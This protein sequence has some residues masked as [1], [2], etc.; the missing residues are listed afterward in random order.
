MPYV[1][2]SECDP[3][4]FTIVG[5]YIPPSECDPIEF[6]IGGEA[7]F[8]LTFNG[9]FSWTGSQVIINGGQE[10]N[11][12]SKIKLPDKQFKW[13][14]T[15]SKVEVHNRGDWGDA[16]V[17]DIEESIVWGNKEYADLLI[18]MPLGNFNL[19][20]ILVRCLWKQAEFLSDMDTAFPAAN[21]L[22]WYDLISRI[23][24][25]SF[26]FYDTSKSFKY[27]YPFWVDKFYRQKYSGLVDANHIMDML[28]GVADPVDHEYDFYWGPY[29]YSLW[30]QKQYYPPI[31]N[32]INF[33]INEP[34][35]T[36]VCS[37]ID[38]YIG[39]EESPRCPFKHKHSGIRD[40]YI[41]VPTPTDH[42][43]YM[44]AYEVYHMLN[45]IL[46]KRLP[47][48]EPLDCFSVDIQTDLD[49]WCWDFSITLPQSSFLDLVKPSVV[50]E[51]LVLID[52]EISINGWKW[53]CRVESWSESFSFGQRAWTIHGRSPSIELSEPYC[54]PG[55]YTNTSV[56]NG[57]QIL[58]EVLFGTGWSIQWG[59]D[60]LPGNYSD[61][62]N[63]T[64]TW[65]IPA[66]ACSVSEKTKLQTIQ[67]ILE[68]IDARIITEPNCATNK[69]LII[70]PRY[71]FTP[72]QWS[73]KTAD[74]AVNI[75]SCWETGGG[76]RTLPKINAVVVSGESQGVIVNAT[77]DGTAGNKIAP[78]FTHPLITTV[79]AGSERA[80]SIL[81]EEGTWNDHTFKLFSLDNY[82]SP[83]GNIPGLLLPGKLLSVI[84]D[85][86][87]WKG[88]VTS[89]SIHGE[90]V[91]ENK[92]CEVTQTIEVEEYYG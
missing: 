35:E 80:K 33:H 65:N 90:A 36:N 6:G 20:D 59:F 45:T 47:S 34:V 16:E 81:S 68:A 46:I 89:V 86:T 3:I 40:Q 61:Y 42:I 9:E 53:V 76:F 12:P 75:A 49:S 64:T 82:V 44:G 4:E 43:I 25:G 13:T 92:G 8:I 29:W 77:K 14:D 52:I 60:N 1:P 31:S 21:N 74:E 17:V 30:C 41:Y 56:V 87:S 54:L 7:L 91:A 57:G 18:R 27:L 55:V 62:L 5:G 83:T 58:D 78:M 39:P 2:P 72:W 24:W 79:E 11:L 26:N 69:N 66:E 28:F 48:N 15:E 23:L 71:K 22:N 51:D 19:E 70:L 10:Y 38:L 63:P 85:L 50:G 84:G 67:Y 73:S 37:E 88:Y 32:N